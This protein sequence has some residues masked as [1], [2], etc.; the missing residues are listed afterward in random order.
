MRGL[1][2]IIYYEKKKLK[3]KAE[4][5]VNNLLMILKKR[6]VNRIE[7]RWVNLSGKMK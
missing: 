2:T 6:M 4:Q 5:S 7:S 1:L 3:I